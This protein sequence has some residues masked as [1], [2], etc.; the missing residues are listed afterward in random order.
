LT[1]TIRSITVGIFVDRKFE[2]DEGST[3]VR[4]MGRLTA[5]QI[6]KAKKPGM[7]PDGGGL[8]LRVTP[9]GA[10]NWV[11]RYML[12]RRPR[13]MGLG[14]VVLYGLQEVR[15]KALDARRKRHEGM[16]PIDARRAERARQR[17]DAAKAVS[18][19]QCA[20][21]YMNAHRAGWRNGKHAGQWGATLSTYAY[22]IIG[23][24][25]VQ[26]VDTGL[27]LKVLEP[28]WTTKPET[29]GRLRGRIESI[30]DYAKVRGYREGE[31]PARWRG[32]LDKLLPAR[33]KVRQVEHHAALP[34]A[35]LPDFLASLRQQEGIAARALEFLILTAARTGEVIA[36]RWSEIDLLDKTWTVPAAR[37]KAHR[38][39]RVPLSARALAI[40][41]EMR[42]AREGDTSDAFVFRGGKAGKPLSNMAFLMLLRRM[43]RGDLTA[44]G[45]R[46]TFKTWASERMSF[47]NEIV[48]ASLAHVIGGKVEQA[49]MRGDMFDKRRRLMQQWA[50]FCTT[51]LPQEAPGNVMPLHRA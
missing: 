2:D 6:E 4:A 16:D 21:A 38:E 14:P 10:K 36:E 25:P 33:S 5:L 51:A 17:L 42:A 1:A 7:Y 13:W 31:N 28:L 20:E 19:R 40:L 35:E 41:D 50:T 44:H 9:E 18:F 27:V 15:A 8:Y 22:P 12:D 45:F 24:L 30:L 26:G 3:M 29:A 11:L 23:R 49:Y 32:H 43:G 39:H 34:Y 47:Q 46:A 37:M 48:E